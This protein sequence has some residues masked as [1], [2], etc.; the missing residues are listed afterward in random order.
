MDPICPTVLTI[1]VPVDGSVFVAVKVFINYANEPTLDVTPTA[2]V[3]NTA[4]VNIATVVIC[5]MRIAVDITFVTTG[6]VLSTGTFVVTATEA[7][8]VDVEIIL[9]S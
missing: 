4:L 8:L 3:V 5:A 2:T 9:L 6:L 7:V 1:E